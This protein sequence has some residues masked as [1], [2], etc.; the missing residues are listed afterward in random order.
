[1]LPHLF[2]DLIYYEKLKKFHKMF[3]L[4]NLTKIFSG[5]FSSTFGQ[6]LAVLRPPFFRPR[7]IF[8]ACFELF[9]RKFGRLATVDL[10]CF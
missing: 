5:L 4:I 3:P 8:G 10:M 1:V 2:I 7:N 9:G 6:K